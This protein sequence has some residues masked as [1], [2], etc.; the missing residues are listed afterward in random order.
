MKI[1][2]CSFFLI[3]VSSF[4]LSPEISAVESCRLLA[5]ASK[6][7][8]IQDIVSRVGSRI[9][10]TIQRRS[11]KNPYVDSAP[12]QFLGNVSVFEKDAVAVIVENPNWKNFLKTQ[13]DIRSLVKSGELLIAS[14]NSEKNKKTIDFAVGCL[15]AGC[16]L[17]GAWL[18]MPL[19]VTSPFLPLALRIGSPDVRGAFRTKF[20]E[21]QSKIVD[22][23]EELSSL[24]TREEKVIYMVVDLPGDYKKMQEKLYLN[25]YRQRT[26]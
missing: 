6:A 11:K 12:S 18:Q 16:A 10:E 2:V 24:D 1:Q 9:E 20:F 19:L 21:K 17:T 8:D 3:F 15:A 13:K 5:I 4:T 22:M 23:L 26:K 14:V 7:N 25:G